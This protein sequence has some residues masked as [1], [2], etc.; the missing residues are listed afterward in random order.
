MMGGD[1]GWPIKLK[2]IKNNVKANK[3]FI[4]GPAKM[5]RIFLYRESLSNSTLFISTCAPNG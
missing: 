2:K 3:K 1:D 5:I 4:N